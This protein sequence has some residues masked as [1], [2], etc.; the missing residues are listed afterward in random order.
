MIHIFKIDPLTYTPFDKNFSK[1]DFY[2]LENKGLKITSNKN[3]ADL[4]LAGNHNSLRRFISKNPL[5][6]NYLIW[7]QEPRFSKIKSSHFYPFLVFPK[8]HLMNVYTGDVFLNN[9]TN[10]DKKFISNSPIKPLEQNFRFENRKVAAL[11][12]YYQGGKNSRLLINGFDIDLIKKRS[13]IA[14]YLFK[15]NM[16][17]I[18]GHGWPHG[19]SKEDSRF[20]QRHSRKKDILRDYHFNLCFENTVYPKYITEKIWESIENKCLPIYYGGARSSIYEIFPQQSF[21][22]YSEIEN[23]ERLKHIIKTMSREEFIDRLNK[24]I[25]VYNSF[26]NKPVQFW[27]NSRKDM[28]DK[29]VEKCELIT[30]N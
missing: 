15:E 18:Y 5:L 28:L 9:V 22:D 29:I 19:I 16:I 24:C 14:I 4:F 11:M 1:D 27:E 17:D 13:E 26:I 8:V 3:K 23:P 21:I 20:N 7:S 6:R 30:N 2:Y 12:S 10:Q 25:A